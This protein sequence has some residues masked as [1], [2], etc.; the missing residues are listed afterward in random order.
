MAPVGHW[1]RADVTP[2]TVPLI[3]A[4][5]RLEV[6]RIEGFGWWAQIFSH[7]AILLCSICTADVAKMLELGKDLMSQVGLRQDTRSYKASGLTLWLD[8]SV[9]ILLFYAEFLKIGVD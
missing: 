5:F 7:T 2:Y 1:P 3:T 9:R 8:G 4:A 6:G